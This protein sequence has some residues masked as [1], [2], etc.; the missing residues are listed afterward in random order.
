MSEKFKSLKVNERREI[1]PEIPTVFQLFET[2]PHV[3]G[4]QKQE[5]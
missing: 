1:C 2:R 5:M 4:L 3:E